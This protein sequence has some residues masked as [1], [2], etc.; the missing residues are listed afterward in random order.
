MSDYVSVQPSDA[1]DAAAVGALSAHPN[2]ADYVR[3]GLDI[4]NPDFSGGT[5]ALSAGE[6]F[7]L[8]DEAQATTEGTM[9]YGVLLT[10]HYD[11]R[12]GQNFDTTAQNYVWA[13]CNGVWPGTPDD[14]PKIDV[15]QSDTA[16]SQDSFLIAT[17]DGPNQT[18]TH[19][20][21]DPD[22]VFEKLEADEVVIR[23]KLEAA[24]LVDTSNLADK[25]VTN[26]KVDDNAIDSRTIGAGEVGSEEIGDGEVNTADMARGSVVEDI[27]AERAIVEGK[28]AVASVY[29]DALQD[30]AVGTSKYATRS[31]TGGKIG[32][33]AIGTRALGSRSV[34]PGK[35]DSRQRY[36]MA[37]LT[38][39]GVTENRAR[40]N[41]VG[42]VGGSEG[43]VRRIGGPTSDAVE[44]VQG[45]AGR[46]YLCWNAEYDGDEWRYVKSGE[47]AMAI[48]MDS[49][50]V[51]MWTADHGSGTINWETT[52]VDNG[53][54]SNAHALG[55]VAAN[56]YL[57]KRGVVDIRGGEL[58]LLQDWDSGREY[59]TS[60]DL[61]FENQP[62][63]DR[64]HMNYA[65]PEMRMFEQG[66][67]RSPF[68]VATK[69]GVFR[70]GSSLELLSDSNVRR[71]PKVGARLYYYNGEIR[72][73]NDAG[74]RDTVH[75][76][77]P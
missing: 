53:G 32:D 60:Q 77:Y 33:S 52:T 58:T 46:Y 25:A 43:E 50:E 65:R 71:P 18:V 47:P 67:F 31:I 3:S 54:I 63:G 21:R 66:H 34:T 37:G 9:R 72:A 29:Q 2:V 62:S 11:A 40:S 64:V 41:A 22:G 27:V 51:Q 35:I 5:F 28:L 7:W 69:R 56:D 30:G 17:I 14:A 38:T 57:R 75:D 24:G 16:P 59:N 4:Q 70:P 6:A 1:G 23:D 49:G 12:T 55:G 20:N 39:G 42:N 76:F 15:T 10:A 26:P 44:I 61:V 68:W 45:G 19:H 8:A 48:G 13:R 36:R 74:R 73:I